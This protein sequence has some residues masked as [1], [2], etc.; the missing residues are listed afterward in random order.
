V[1]S[2]A[3][4]TKGRATMAKK[5]TPIAPLPVRASNATAA[6]ACA[7][8]IALSTKCPNK[9]FEDKHPAAMGTVAHIELAKIVAGEKVDF[10]NLS[11]G[12]RYPV[13]SGKRMWEEGIPEEEIEPLH[14]YFPGER[15]VEYAVQDGDTTGHIDLVSYDP[16]EKVL[17]VLD[18]KTGW[19]LGDH[20]AQLLVYAHLYI[21]QEKIEPSHIMLM[22]AYPRQNDIAWR[23]VTADQLSMTIQKIQTNALS[24]A[25]WV[26]SRKSMADLSIFTE[27]PHCLQCNNKA[28]CPAK[29]AL[30]VPLA[31]GKIAFV[32]D[33][34]KAVDASELATAYINIKAVE[35]VIADA[36]QAVTEQVL[37]RG[38]IAIGD[39][40]E[41]GIVESEDVA[42]LFDRCGEWL[43]A[44]NHIEFDVNG[45]THRLT[46]FPRPEII[47]KVLKFDK[48]AF[49]THVK[50]HCPRGTKKLAWNALVKEL[51]SM[52]AVKRSRKNPYI[53]IRNA[54][55]A[56]PND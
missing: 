41:L 28:F 6:I 20:W 18:W 42:I 19:V 5:K 26:K 50:S 1:Q 22:V 25:Q 29:R 49:E 38:P 24:A 15:K 4:A 44:G 32:Q 8:S 48:A 2:I 23:T 7:G 14:S 51:E 46:P 40:K 43:K 33:W 21:Q 34:A 45:E 39:G 17:A 13:W 10:K 11:D 35:A 55:E 16:D 37:T 52:G 12:V 9:Q 27:G 54:K 47:S 30:I 3:Q 56:D 36:K 53:R 31:T